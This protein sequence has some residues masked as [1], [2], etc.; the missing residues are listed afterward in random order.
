MSNITATFYEDSLTEEFQNL[1]LLAPYEVLK[2]EEEIEILREQVESFK[3]L[4]HQQE[5]KTQEIA[6]ELIETKY[7]LTQ[8]NQELCYVLHCHKVAGDNLRTG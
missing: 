8:T 1:K 6:Q 3:Q 7:E 5:Q 2:F 4:L